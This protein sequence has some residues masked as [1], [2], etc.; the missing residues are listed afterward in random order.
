MATYWVQDLPNITG[1]S[2]HLWH[3]TLIFAEING[4]AYACSK[5]H[6]NLAENHKHIGIKWVGTGKECI[7]MG[8][9]FVSAV[10]KV[11]VELFVYLNSMVCTANWPR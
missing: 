3:S 2:G 9:E 1:F 4:A 5:K 8:T 6:I 10:G 7:A 11:P